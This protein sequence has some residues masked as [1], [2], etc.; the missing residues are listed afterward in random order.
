MKYYRFMDEENEDYSEAYIIEVPED[1]VSALEDIEGISQ[2]L[3]YWVAGILDDKGFEYE[4]ILLNDYGSGDIAVN[5]ISKKA[6][7][8]LDNYAWRSFWKRFKHNVIGD[9][10]INTSKIGK[11]KVISTITTTFGRYI[12]DKEISDGSREYILKFYIKV[13]PDAETFSIFIYSLSEDGETQ[14]TVYQQIPDPERKNFR[15]TLDRINYTQSFSEVLD[16]IRSKINEA[17]K[18]YN[19]K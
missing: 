15:I 14:Y 16:F 3:Y 17:I 6:Y 5:G 12:I 9:E 7:N 11:K 10:V 13:S 4:E 8:Y 1:I 19:Y 2:E 18:Q